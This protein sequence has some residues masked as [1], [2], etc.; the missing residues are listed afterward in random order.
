MGDHNSLRAAKELSSLIKELSE[1]YIIL[2]EAAVK[3]SGVSLAGKN[4]INEALRRASC[5]GQSLDNCNA[6]LYFL[7]KTCFLDY[8]HPANHT[9]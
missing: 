6:A 4:E 8:F 7:T 1:S 2:V 5:L 3:L 9:K